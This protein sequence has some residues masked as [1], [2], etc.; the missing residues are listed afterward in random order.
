MSADKCP[1]CGADPANDLIWECGVW[2][3]TT[4]MW[5]PVCRERIAHAATKREL[6]QAR[7]ECGIA[8]DQ[9]RDEASRSKIAEER[10]EK[11]EARVA[12]LEGL[13]IAELRDALHR[14]SHQIWPS[15][16]H[17]DDCT[18]CRLDRQF[19]RMIEALGQA[20]PGGV[21]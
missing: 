19:T 1:H 8:H 12:E 14:S 2:K 15:G 5:T 7:A 10:A 11:A 17:A 16:L 3:I 18:G 9:R 13:R 4:D 21:R 6:E 20:M